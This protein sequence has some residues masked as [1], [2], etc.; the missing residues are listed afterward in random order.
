MLGCEVLPARTGLMT[1]S[2]ADALVRRLVAN[3]IESHPAY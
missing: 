3:W 2:E 1:M